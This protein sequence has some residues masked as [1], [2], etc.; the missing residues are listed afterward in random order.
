MRSLDGQGGR[1][2]AS[3][4]VLDARPIA[5]R[6]RFKKLFQGEGIWW[7]GLGLLVIVWCVV[8]WYGST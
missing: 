8:V 5:S 3:V 2:I 4:R 7:V 1:P 6:R